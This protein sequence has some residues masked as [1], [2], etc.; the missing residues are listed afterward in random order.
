MIEFDSVSL[1]LNNR[2]ILNGLSF[3]IEKGQT[4]VLVGS[5][6]AGKS[7]ILRLILGLLK[8]TSGRVLIVD[9]DINMMPEKA[10]NKIRQKFSLVF[11]NGA[12]FDSLTLQEN[13]GFFLN[14]HSSLAAQEIQDRVLEM[15]K[16]FGLEDFMHYYPSQISGGMKK[17][18]SIARAVVTNP[19]VMLYDEPTAGLDPFAAKK[20]VNLIDRLKESFNM[21]SLIVTHEIHHFEN[22]V[23]RLLM[24]KN[25][26]ITYDGAYD[27]SILDQFEETELQAQ[28]IP[29]EEFYADFV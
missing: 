2:T 22:V 19:E 20:V 6:G 16:F 17:R 7:T 28:C 27:L 26:L 10:L 4:V 13:V 12:L 5:S 14:E 15:M 8:P 3:R 25:G 21:T 23:N 1:C 9:K 18:V 24:L 29:D 11:Q